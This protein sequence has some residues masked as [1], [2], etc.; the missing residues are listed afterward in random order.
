METE[1][2]T[3]NSCPKLEG[4]LQTFWGEIFHDGDEYIRSFF[5]YY[6]SD[7]Y[8]RI[9]VK[10]GNII[11]TLYGIK[12]TFH[13]ADSVYSGV[14]LCGLATAENHRKQGI[15]SRML[16]DFIEEIDSDGA[17]D[18]VFLIPADSHLREYYATFGFE[19]SGELKRRYL[20]A[21]KDQTGG[22]IAF[23]Q[24]LSELSKQD[25]SIKI[26]GKSNPLVCGN[27]DFDGVI[28]R[29]IETE[30]IA[31]EGISICHSRRDWEAIL[32]DIF[33]SNNL[34]IVDWNA[35]DS[36]ET[37]VVLTNEGEL[38]ILCGDDDSLSRLLKNLCEIAIEEGQSNLLMDVSYETVECPYGMVR[39][40]SKSQG[41]ENRIFDKNRGFP[42][43]YQKMK[44]DK[45]T[46]IPEKFI[47]RNV[48]FKYMLD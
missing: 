9:L 40:L 33:I 24:S 45:N 48:H 2:V 5:Q 46:V 12:Y 13:S 10:N 8:K 35:P 27:C 43:E 21:P 25:I 41:P 47:G 14:Y 38:K 34:L 28:S 22:F 20:C 30:F 16:D 3:I 19:N 1:Y 4:A 6:F 42:G 31:D 32:S 18:F 36:I 26:Y 7:S 37:I 39:F 17:V 11:A 29:C 15:M 44:S 23:V